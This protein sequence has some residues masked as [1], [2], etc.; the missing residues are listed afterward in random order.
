MATADLRDRI[1]NTISRRGVH[2]IDLAVR[3]EGKGKVV[4]L[5]IDS[6]DGV[7]TDV[8]TEVSREVG[9]LIETS[10]V[11]GRSYTLTVSSPGISRPLKY[12][13]QYKKHIGRQLTVK[14]HSEGGV[15]SLM[16]TMESLTEDSLVLA[17]AASGL[18]EVIP[19]AAI[20]DARVK[21]P[22]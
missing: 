3:G 11:V 13:W 10:G 19:L 14:V 21:T 2:L 18:H 6:E 8:C 15:R 12:P 17:S 4:E 16:G 9:P 22:W 7:T 20:V 1:E 5:Y